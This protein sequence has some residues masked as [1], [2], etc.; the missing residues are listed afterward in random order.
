MKRKEKICDMIHKCNALATEFRDRSPIDVTSVEIYFYFDFY[1]KLSRD[2]VEA[3][4]LSAHR[5]AQIA[6]RSISSGEIKRQSCFSF[7]IARWFHKHHRSGENQN[8]LNCR[9]V[10]TRFLIQPVKGD[11]KYDCMFAAEVI[12]CNEKRFVESLV[13]KSRSRAQKKI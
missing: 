6:V 3:A 5:V 12:L 11:F 7:H 8:Q 10:R 9:P 1:M 13:G 2:W 4:L